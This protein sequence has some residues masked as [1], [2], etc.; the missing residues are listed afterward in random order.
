MNVHRKKIAGLFFVRRENVPAIEKKKIAVLFSGRG[1]NMM[2]LYQA[3]QNDS[4][5]YEIVLTITDNE[6]APG[7]EKVQ[8]LGLPCIVIGKNNF[9]TKL[10]KAI[11][12]SKA[13]Y[14]CLAG[15]MK[16]LSPEFVKKWPNKIINIHPS[17]LPKFKGLNTHKRALQANEKIHGCT[18][19]FVNEKLDD[20]EIIMQKKIAIEKNDCE[21]TLAKKVLAMEHIIYPQALNSL[22]K[23]DIKHNKQTKH[24]KQT[25]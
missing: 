6:N 1:T 11:L 19:H 3:W 14:I 8:K 5:P 12:N 24:T 13:Q 10:H 18:V 23:K 25:Q 21:K 20:G 16:I 9:E 15:F 17:L 22:I 2:A 4:L 7:I